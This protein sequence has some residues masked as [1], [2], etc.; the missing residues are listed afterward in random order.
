MSNNL[1]DTVHLQS[2][3]N[4]SGYE[5]LERD[6]KGLQWAQVALSSGK[7]LAASFPGSNEC[8]GAYCS[9]IEQEGEDSSCQ[10]DGGKRKDGEGGRAQSESQR[11]VADLLVLPRPAKS[12]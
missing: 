7:L 2:E 12:M 4:N 3:K 10:R 8:P 11:E 9:L 1:D 5:R 6:Y